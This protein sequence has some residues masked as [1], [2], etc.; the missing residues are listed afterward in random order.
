MATY[1]NSFVPTW[2]HTSYPA[3]SENN[4][5]LSAK[6]KI[7][8]ITGGGRGIGRAIA[9]SFAIAKAEAIFLIGRNENDLSQTAGIVAQLASSSST[10]TE[11]AVADITDLRAVS[12]AIQKAKLTYGRIDILVQNAGYLDAHRPVADS[13][14]DDYWRTFEVNVKGGLTVIQEFLK[15]RPNPGATLIN[16]SSGA[17]HLPYIPGFSAYAASKLS[18]AKI[19]EYI[20][21]ENPDLRV[22]NINPGAIATDMQAK[23]GGVV[24]A[25]DEIGMS[26]TEPLLYIS[27][28]S[29]YDN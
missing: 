18:L 7:V 27:G 4:P 8:L 17:G 29:A 14:L 2:H 26:A 23:A 19:V 24:A 20:Q 6:G 21:H 10:K 22:F 11:F 16:I 9:T 1:Q 13:D 25:P 15:T 3:I 12:S 5:A 28:L